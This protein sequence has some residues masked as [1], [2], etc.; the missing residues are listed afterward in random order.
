MSSKFENIFFASVSNQFDDKQAIM[1]MDKDIGKNLTAPAFYRLVSMKVLSNY[2]CALDAALKGCS[3]VSNPKP[4]QSVKQT[5]YY[6]SNNINAAAAPSAT[7][8][9]SAEI[10]ALLNPHAPVPVLEADMAAAHTRFR[11]GVEALITKLATMDFDDEAEE[12]EAHLASYNIESKLSRFSELK[13]SAHADTASEVVATFGRFALSKV[14]AM[15]KVSNQAY[16]KFGG[17]LSA[18]MVKYNHD[19]LEQ[20]RDKAKELHPAAKSGCVLM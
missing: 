4:A 3:T 14:D 8:I 17:S 2:L 15:A 7:E 18:V 10:H 12:K 20:L 9:L 5:L 6:I 16:V 19:L 11:D 13:D 1:E